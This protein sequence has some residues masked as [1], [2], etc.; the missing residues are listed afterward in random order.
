[1]A[2]AKLTLIGLYNYDPTIFAPLKLPDGLDAGIAAE[3]IL[4]EKGEFPVLYTDPNF[5]KYA[6]GTWSRQNQFMFEHLAAVQKSVY[7][8]LWNYDR[9]EEE[10]ITDDGSTSS[11]G[12]SAQEDRV[13]AFNSSDYQ[14]SAK[15]DFSEENTIKDKNQRKRKF[16][17]YGNI[18]VTTSAQMLLQEKE[19]VEEM[20]Q[21]MILADLFADAFCIKI[22]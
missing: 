2:L 8:P 21:Y 15:N 1:M 18:G 7:N 10:D 20:N 19:V 11:E 13:S 4:R 17:S 6:I 16:R 12:K 3:V 5:L 9:T 22:Y 14:P